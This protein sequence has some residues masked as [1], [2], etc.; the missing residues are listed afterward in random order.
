EQLEVL[1]VSIMEI[2]RITELYEESRAEVGKPKV[3]VPLYEP[4]PAVRDW[5]KERALARLD[6]AIRSADKQAREQAMADLKAQLLE[7]FQQEWGEE[8][9]ANNAKDVENVYDSL[10]KEHV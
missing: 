8:A 1:M 10:I 4:D 9:F 7:E 2:Q 6:S 3:E 5:V